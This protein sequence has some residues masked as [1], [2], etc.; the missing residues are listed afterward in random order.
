MKKLIIF[1]TFFLLIISFIHTKEDS[2][3]VASINEYN[4]NNCYE[5]DFSN[6]LLNFRNFKLKLGLFTSYNYDIKKVY[7][8]YPEKIKDYL[9]EKRY[10]SFDSSDFNLGIEKVKEEYNILLKE[11]YLFDEL[12]DDINNVVI[13][14]VFI[15]AEDAGIKKFEN[16][17]PNVIVKKNEKI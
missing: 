14:K 5:L 6:E 3:E 10:F 8:N 7:I 12:D 11:K 17:Y 2:I 13:K 1:L 16:K 15:C 4:N 9:K